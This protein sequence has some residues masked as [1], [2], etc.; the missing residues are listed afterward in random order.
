MISGLMTFARAGK[1]VKMRRNRGWSALSFPPRLS[2]ARRFAF[3]NELLS[4]GRRQISARECIVVGRVEAS[5][6]GDLSGGNN[7]RSVHFRTCCA[8]SAGQRAERKRDTSTRKR[9]HTH[10][11]TRVYTVY[12]P[13]TTFMQSGAGRRAREKGLLALGAIRVVRYRTAADFSLRAPGR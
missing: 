11:H 9:A 13:V 3:R 2:I 1:K 4:P 5:A 10:T 8:T 6:S 7:R 12:P